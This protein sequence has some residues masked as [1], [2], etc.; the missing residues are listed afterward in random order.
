MAKSRA[1][2][3]VDRLR[4]LQAS[5]SDVEAS[6]VVSVSS[7]GGSCGA[8]TYGA[9]TSVARQANFFTEEDM[10]LLGALAS[11]AIVAIEN[12]ALYE[13]SEKRGKR[14][15]ALVHISQRLARELDLANVLESISNAA[16]TLFDGDAGFRLLQGN[17]LVRQGATPGA[18]ERMGRK[19]IS[20]G[21]PI[22]GIVAQTGEPFIT[23][24]SSADL[25][26]THD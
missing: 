4:D 26:I 20:I 12:A 2:L 8:V 7:S 5:T 6:A 18:L 15:T 11:Q 10:K 1:E 13:E 16:A 23:E 17:Q 3:M 25:R 9:I 24:N 19:K 22:A 21:E 14:L